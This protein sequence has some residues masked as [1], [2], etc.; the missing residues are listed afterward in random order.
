MARRPRF[1]P[2]GGRTSSG[3]H[4]R[5]R[6][7]RAPAGWAW[8]PPRP[9][10]RGACPAAPRRGGPGRRRRPGARRV[11]PPPAHGPHG[12]RAADLARQ[13]PIGAGFAERDREQRVPDLLLERGT[14]IIELHGERLPLAGEIL[15][16]LAFGLDEH[17]VVGGL[18]GGLQPHA[19]R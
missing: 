9:R 12:G 8:P 18:D 14:A 13:L 1:T 3:P 15:A 17:G 4:R 10:S 2:C 6:R 16:E 11:A 19:I 5:S 7:P